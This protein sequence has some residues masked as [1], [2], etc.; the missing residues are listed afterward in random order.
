[1]KILIICAAFLMATNLSVGQI[2]I[3]YEDYPPVPYSTW[4]YV[5]TTLENIDV[6]S[7]GNQSSLGFIKF[8]P[9]RLFFTT[10]HRFDFFT[11][12][13]TLS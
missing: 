2:T 8:S 1:M 10:I 12:C 9:L 4:E 3:T 5:P 6:L 13:W 11:F 7:N